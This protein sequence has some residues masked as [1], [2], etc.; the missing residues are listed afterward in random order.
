[1]SVAGRAVDDE[2]ADDTLPTIMWTTTEV[3]A[4]IREMIP[5]HFVSLIPAQSFVTGIEGV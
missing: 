3:P 2:R 1:M 4:G 5:N